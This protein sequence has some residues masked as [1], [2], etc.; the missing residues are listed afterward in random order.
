MGFRD[1]GF[2]KEILSHMPVF[3]IKHVHTHLQTGSNY[4][5]VLIKL[6]LYSLE[7]NVLRFNV[8]FINMF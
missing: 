8:T 6:L 1:L 3:E 4:T 7:C 5:Y 2:L